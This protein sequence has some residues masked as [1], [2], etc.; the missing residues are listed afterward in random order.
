MSTRP[1]SS[2]RGEGADNLSY[3]ECFDLLSNY[4]RRC[5]LHYLEQHE[6]A[7]ISDLSEQV[8]AWEYE[9]A[10]EEV[11]YDERK[12]VYTSLQQV[13]LPRMDEVGVVEFDSDQGTVETG[14]AAEE[15]DIYL[16]V[17]TG[18]DVPWSVLYV[19]LAGVS[20]ALIG[21]ATAGAPVL[22]SIPPVG[23]AVFVVTTFLFVS[24]AH[25]YL[26]R[27]EMRLGAGEP[28]DAGR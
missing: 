24:A 9:Q 19:A 16:D 13:H 28:P 23:W 25:T 18:R 6:E 7:T 8:A 14:P 5:T 2:E 4:R 17:V 26:A 1:V 3:D 12:R 21:V 10:P 20:A 11:S 22:G 27:T 15:L